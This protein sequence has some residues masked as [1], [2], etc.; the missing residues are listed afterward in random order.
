VSELQRA[1]E[2]MRRT[3]ERRAR[4]REP[5]AWGELLVDD[6]LPT[7]WDANL[8]IVDRWDCS[9]AELRDEI[10]RVQEAAGFR[11][12]K[13]N[14]YDQEL[15]ARIAPGFAELGW[16]FVNRYAVMALR[17]EPDRAAPAGVAGEIDRAAFEA[18]KAEADASEEHAS[19]VVDLLTEHSRR[20][21]A[22]V[23]MRLFGALVDGEPAAY[24]ELRFDGRT[25]QIEDVAT[26]PRFRNRGLARATVLAAADAARASGHD[27]VFLVADTADWPIR[28]YRKL[29]FDELGSEWNFGRPGPAE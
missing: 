14:I 9:A 25:A 5:Q 10:D 26:V 20:T 24:C 1:L 11:H 15:G 12:R 22:A 3:N 21:A 17:R 23:D 19:A 27:L 28:L 7:V 6:D 8:A 13:L 18:A 2:F 29:G 4:R 16:Q